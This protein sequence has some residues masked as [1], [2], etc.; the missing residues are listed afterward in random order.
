M[1]TWQAGSVTG[2]SSTTQ[3]MSSAKHMRL[4]LP[5]ITEQM[6]GAAYGVMP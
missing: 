2:D 1:T 3:F 4:D 5:S 6:D